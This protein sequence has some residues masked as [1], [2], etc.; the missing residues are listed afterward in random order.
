MRRL[1]LLFATVVA[2]LLLGSDSSKDYDDQIEI[3]GL[4]G[5]GRIWKAEVF[6][7]NTGYRSRS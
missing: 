3:D 4:E 2:L 7:G 5:H 6:Q 1:M